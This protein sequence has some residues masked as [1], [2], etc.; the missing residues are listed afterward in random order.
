[1]SRFLS[2]SLLSAD[3]Q[4]S[5]TDSGKDQAK[6]RATGGCGLG[7]PQGVKDRGIYAS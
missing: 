4:L 5:F 3:L 7:V 2:D 6:R 1:M